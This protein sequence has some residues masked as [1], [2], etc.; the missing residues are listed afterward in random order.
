MDLGDLLYDEGVG[1]EV[2]GVVEQLPHGGVLSEPL[3][4]VLALVTGL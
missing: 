3:E 1:M 2:E 4:K